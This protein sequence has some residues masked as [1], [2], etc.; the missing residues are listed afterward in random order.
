[1]AWSGSSTNH[2]VGEKVD[3]KVNLVKHHWKSMSLLA[4]SRPIYRAI[5]P[6]VERTYIYMCIE[7]GNKLFLPS[8][9]NTFNNFSWKAKQNFIIL[10][11]FDQKNLSNYWICAVSFMTMPVLFFFWS[12][13]RCQFC[14]VVFGKQLG[15]VEVMD[16]WWR[17]FRNWA[18]QKFCA[19]AS[20]LVG[21]FRP[22]SPL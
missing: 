17:R 22:K 9:K 19:N 20:G 16:W 21:L 6:R 5:N 1:M 12:K 18:F 2:N 10:S 15:S 14:T 8:R 13:W 4:P 7:F 3:K 11:W